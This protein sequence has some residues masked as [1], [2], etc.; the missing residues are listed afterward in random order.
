[1]ALEQGVRDM[2]TRRSGL[3]SNKW[4]GGGLQLLCRAP[5]A[6]HGGVAGRDWRVSMQE[7]TIAGRAGATLRGP[8][9]VR[10][11]ARLSTA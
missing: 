9:V 11:A 6:A 1:M 5:M 10:R 3:D 2:G 4:G 7:E 8:S